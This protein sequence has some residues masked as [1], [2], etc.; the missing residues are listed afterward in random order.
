MRAPMMTFAV[1]LRARRRCD[2]RNRCRLR[3]SLR[4]RIAATGKSKARSG[5][6]KWPT[7][8]CSVGVKRGG[9]DDPFSASVPLP[10]FAKSVR[11]RQSNAAKSKPPEKE[12]S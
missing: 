2:L 4:L 7:A 10:V 1:E 9:K 8:E 6:A 11:L 5:K 12:T 3:D